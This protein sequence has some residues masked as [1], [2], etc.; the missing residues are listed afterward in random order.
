MNYQPLAQHQEEAV[1]EEE[2]NRN[3]IIDDAPSHNSSITTDTC[4]NNTIDY[5]R[6][7]ED[8]RIEYEQYKQSM[9]KIVQAQHEHPPSQMVIHDEM[10]VLC[11]HDVMER[12]SSSIPDDLMIQK[13][14]LHLSNMELEPTCYPENEPSSDFSRR[15]RN[16][17]QKCARL[18]SWESRTDHNSNVLEDDSSPPKFDPE[19]D[20]HCHQQ[21]HAHNFPQLTVKDRAAWLVMLLL[22]QSFSGIILGGNADLL[23]DHPAIVYFLTMLVGAGGNAGNQAA[24]Q[25]IREMALGQVDH[26]T[27]WKY[28]SKEAK[29]GLFLSFILALFG[30]MRA[31]FFQ[32]PLPETVAVTVTLAVIVFVSIVFGVTLPLLLKKCGV[33]PVHSSTTIQVV[34][35]ILGVLLTVTVSGIVLEGI[36]G[37]ILFGNYT[38]ED[39]SL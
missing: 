2:G 37:E 38:E 25:M 39:D 18:F 21:A 13:D 14:A 20:D 36:V 9:Q 7:Y 16:L 4:M 3:S 27:Q 15:N 30:C 1:R 17:C 34:M 22:L 8:L 19:H 23:S 12:G 32:T 11:D 5:Q 29:N 24:V 6:L 31:W 35:D 10:K 28:V 26:T 33:D